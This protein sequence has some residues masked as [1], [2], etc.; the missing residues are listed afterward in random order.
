MLENGADTRYVQAL[1]GHEALQSTQDLHEGG[2]SKAQGGAHGDAPVGE[3][4][5]A[6]ERRGGRRHRRR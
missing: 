6:R 5:Q 2:D 1:L 3:A 4:G